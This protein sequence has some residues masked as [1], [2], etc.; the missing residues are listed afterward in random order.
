MFL[1][2]SIS[3]GFGVFLFQHLIL[4]IS[5]WIS[6]HSFPK[7]VKSSFYFFVFACSFISLRLISKQK[8]M[9]AGNFNGKKKGAGFHMYYFCMYY[10]DGFEHV[11]TFITQADLELLLNRHLLVFQLNIIE[12][13]P[14]TKCC[15]QGLHTVQQF[16]QSGFIKIDLIGIKENMTQLSFHLR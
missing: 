8:G 4:L 16:I 5:L 13:V 1:F 7:W 10:T 14:K 12:P 15:M 6:V 2:L 9:L 11:L 3:N